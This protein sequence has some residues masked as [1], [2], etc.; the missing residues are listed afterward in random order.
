MYELEANIDVDSFYASIDSTY[1]EN[2]EEILFGLFAC[3]VPCADIEVQ[4]FPD[5]GK[6]RILVRGVEKYELRWE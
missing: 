6:S 5:L 4:K 2:L 1:K 3:G